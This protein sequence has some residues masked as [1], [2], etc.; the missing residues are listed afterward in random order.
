MKSKLKAKVIRKFALQVIMVA[1]AGVVGGI[2]FKTFFESNGII[3]TGI[4]GLSLIIHNLFANASINIPTSVVYTV[5]NVII[6]SVALK[7]FGWK[8]LLLSIIGTATYTLSMQFGDFAYVLQGGNDDKL[9]YAIVGAMI[10]GLSIGVAF[11]FGGSTGGSEVGGTIINKFFPRLKTGYCLMVFNIIVI[12]LTA[13]FGGV[14]T[15]LYALVITVISSL[16][17]NLV[18]DGSKRIVSMYI[19]TNKDEEIS[20]M[21]LNNFHRGVTKIDAIGEFS[22]QKRSILITLIPHS[23]LS[24]FKKA[25]VEIDK[26]AFM[27]SSIAMETI[28]EGHIVDKKSPFKTKVKNSKISLKSEKSYKRTRFKNKKRLAKSLKFRKYQKT[29]SGKIYKSQKKIYKNSKQG[30]E[31]SCAVKKKYILKNKNN[32]NNI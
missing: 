7:L 12:I 15:C 3:P 30:Q 21:I 10:Y 26:N 6:F 5:I 8:F 25:I 24:Q 27:F 14:S 16:T 9:L 23:K 29:Q 31:N 32:L 4:S 2:T 22:K 20:Q 11:R 19:I 1:L 18:L 28:G 17:T 13:I